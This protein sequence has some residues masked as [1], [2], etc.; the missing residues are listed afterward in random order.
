MH[1]ASYFERALKRLRVLMLVLAAAGGL[2][3]LWWGGWAWALGFLAGAAASL[4]NFHWLH[5]LTSSIGSGGRKPGKRLL[6]FLAT[7]Y[8]LLGVCGYAIVSVFG[9]NLTAALVGLLVAAAAVIVEILYELIYA[10][11]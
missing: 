1:E 9:F 10:G 2:A 7:R 5:Q 6:I 3:S 8:F 11:T 4:V